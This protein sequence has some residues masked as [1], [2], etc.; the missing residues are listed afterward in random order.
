MKFPKIGYYLIIP[1]GLPM[2]S[3]MNQDDE[4]IV[5]N[6]SKLRSPVYSLTQHSQYL[7]FKFKPCLVFLRAV[8]TPLSI[9]L[10]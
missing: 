10:C 8:V 5:S 4:R 1:M 2:M 3:I 6:S 9:R 7:P